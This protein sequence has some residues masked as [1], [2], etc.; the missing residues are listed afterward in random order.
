MKFLLA[1]DSFKGSISSLEAANAFEAGI[2]RVK[3]NVEVIKIPIA[4]GGEGTVESLVNFTKGEIIKTKVK[5]PLM[6]EI[7]SYFG[8]LGDG[9]TVV[10][11]MAAASGLPLL[12]DDERNP[13]YTTTYGT[14]ELIKKAL[15][16]GFRRFVLGIGGSA[17]NDAG[18]GMAMALGFKFLDKE[19]YDIGLGG[20]KLFNLH[21]I[22]TTCKDKRL[23]ECEFLVACDVENTLYGEKGATY[24]YARQ[25]GAGEEDLILLE[26]SIVNFSNVVFK[27]FGI[28]IS[29]IKGGGAAGGLGAGAYVFL[30]GKIKKGIDVLIDILKL[31][32][33]VKDVDFVVTGEGKIDGQTLSGKVP[34]GI[35][36]LSKN[37]NKPVIAVCGLLE[38]GYKEIYNYGVDTIFSITNGPISLNESMKNASVL[39]E[40]TAERIIRFINIFK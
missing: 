25:K 32:E 10:I 20:V 3:N 23:D 22:D 6:R 33:V 2:K 9:E 28:N 39:I 34:F 15:D 17:T 1:I 38:E 16:M 31:D 30:N 12:K 29:E 37:Y 36:K 8:I 5:D 4:D 24:V 13:L 7:D 26:K 11:E 27:E 14:G 18:V 35:A 21:S 19:G 40:D